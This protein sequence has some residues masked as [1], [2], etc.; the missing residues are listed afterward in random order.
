ML[1]FLER[2]FSKC[3]PKVKENLYNA[4]VRPLLEYGCCVWDPY[5]DNQIDRLEMINK[6]GA[7][8]VTN[9][10]KMIHGNSDKN[11]NSLGWSPLSLRRSKNKLI[12]LFKIRTNQVHIPPEE[13][14]LIQNFRK[15]LNYFVPQS[16]VDSH[17]HS[18]Y[19]S[20]I[21]LWNS[22]PNSIKTSTSTSLFKSS[23][24]KNSITKLS[25]KF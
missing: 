1:S 24:E 11:M 25:Y 7:R 2:N 8:F 19:P 9:N 15:P 18:F 22:L 20:T 21:R 14:D 16:S 4:L 5:F 12:M 23:L 3:P 6:R 17:I 13:L 10:Y